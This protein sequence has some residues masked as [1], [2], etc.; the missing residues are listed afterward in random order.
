MPSST[1]TI[2]VDTAVKMRLEKLAM[3]TARSR[4][5]LTAAAIEEYLDANEWQVAGIRK[6]MASLDGGE[7][8]AHQ[9]VGDWIASWGGKAERPAPKRRRK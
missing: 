5:F 4:S 3:S 8:V 1:L 7:G 9:D 6:A 2:R